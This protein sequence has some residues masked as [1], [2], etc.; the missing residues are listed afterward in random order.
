[1]KKLKS[2]WIN[3]R[4]IIWKNNDRVFRIGTKTYSY[5]TGGNDENK[6]A[7]G[8]KKCA[9][10][11]KLNFSDYKNCLERNQLEKEINNL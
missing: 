2:Y 5:L 9:I 8:I 10:K 7:K 1:M 11:Q 3:E 6:K 4:W